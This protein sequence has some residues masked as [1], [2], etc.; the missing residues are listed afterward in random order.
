VGGSGLL[1]LE[2]LTSPL[3]SIP[4]ARPAPTAPP[5]APPPS[6]LPSPVRSLSVGDPSLPPPSPRPR[7]VSPKGPYFPL[8][9]CKN[10]GIY[11][12]RSWL[13]A[14]LRRVRE[15]RAMSSNSGNPPYLPRPQFL[16]LLLHI[17]GKLRIS[18]VCS[19]RPPFSSL[20]SPRL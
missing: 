19:W 3:H 12:P 6:P 4:P 11:P 10:L 18:R 2:L 20:V 1:F 7:R 14:L 9:L 15:R 8:L 17:H 13:E 5:R 16:L